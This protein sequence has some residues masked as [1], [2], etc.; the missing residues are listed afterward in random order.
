MHQAGSTDH[1]ISYLVENKT[2]PH[3]LSCFQSGFS[4]LKLKAFERD[5]ASSSLG[6]AYNCQVGCPRVQDSFFLVLRVC[7]AE[8]SLPELLGQEVSGQEGSNYPVIVVII[9]SN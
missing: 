3:S 4:N 5:V 9:P 8:E 6:V 1:W 2:R 7:F